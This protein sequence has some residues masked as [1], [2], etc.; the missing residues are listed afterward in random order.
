MLVNGI[1]HVKIRTIVARQFPPCGRSSVGL[2][3]N[4]C[5]SHHWR[6]L[7]KAYYWLH[8]I[9]WLK[10]RHRCAGRLVVGS[11]RATLRQRWIDATG[12]NG[13]RQGYPGGYPAR[14]VRLRPQLGLD[15]PAAGR[16]ASGAPAR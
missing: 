15:R 10:P 9:I 4:G 1:A 13:T 14:A 11:I 6:L 7:I 2:E 5:K 12:G 8:T 16:G 3:C